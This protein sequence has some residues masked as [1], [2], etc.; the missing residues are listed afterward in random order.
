MKFRAARDNN[1]VNE[2]PNLYSDD[3]EYGKIGERGLELGILTPQSP[4][5]HTHII[6]FD[7]LAVAE[8]DNQNGKADGG[9][10]CCDR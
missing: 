6:D 8:I 2:L 4:F 7:G 9:F 3:E 1:S 5:H 10:G